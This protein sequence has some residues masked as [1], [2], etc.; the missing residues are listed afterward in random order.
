MNLSV[1]NQFD[2]SG[3]MTRESFLIKNFTDEYNYIVDYCISNNIVDVSF[4]E[5]VYLAINNINTIPSCLNCGKSVKFKNSKIGYLKYCSLKCVSSDPEIKKRKQEKSILKY[6]TKTPAE[7]KSV[8]DKIVKTNQIRYGGNSPMCLSEIQ[9]KSKNTLF[10]NYGVDNPNKSLDINK[11]RIESFKLSSYKESYKKTSIERYGVDHPWMNKD[12]HSKTI[13]HFYDDYRKRINNKINKNEFI[14]IGFEKQIS[15]NLIF[16]CNKC[17]SDFKILTYQFYHRVNSG[18]SI[19]TKCFPISEKA[20]IAQVEMYKF[21]QENYDGSVLIDNKDSIPPY[22]IDIYLPDLKIGFEFNGLWWHSNKFKDERYHLNKKE[23]SE[24]TGIRLYTIWEDDWNIKRDICKSYILNK[25]GK[26][27]KI[28]ARNCQVK[29]V[30]YNTSKSFLNDSHFQGDCKSSIRIGLFYESKIVSLMT[31]SKLRLPIGGRNKDGVYELTRFCNRIFCNV[32]GGSSK[33][34]KHFIRKYKPIKIETYSDNLISN[35][36][37]Y[38]KI[39][40]TYLHTSKPGYWYV[41]DEKREHRF[42]WR[43][44][45]LKKLGA[46]MNKTEN[47]IMEEWGFYRVYNAGNKKWIYELKY[48][49]I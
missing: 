49:D 48:E 42:N 33:L 3:R 34:L 15:T 1:F 47:E 22:E 17:N 25:L 6:G 37:M 4:K 46:D 23:M 24:N 21:I 18:L 39:G 36:D 27:K 30:D 5:K 13:D 11:K 40:F 31:F 41:V 45:K 38:K 28:M 12:I 7:A 19:C 44:S 43:K 14:F 20:S 29:E 32:V 16:I 8:K 9:E 26:S 2:P 35:G 10:L